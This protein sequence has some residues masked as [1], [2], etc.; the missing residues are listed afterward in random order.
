MEI[1]FNTYE[2]LSA[3][4]SINFSDKSLRVVVKKWIIQFLAF[5]FDN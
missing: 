3:N 2:S 5:K 4:E 1:I